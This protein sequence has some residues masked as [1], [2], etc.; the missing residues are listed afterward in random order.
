MMCK[1]YL[2]KA[3]KINHPW[4]SMCLRSAQ[5]CVSMRLLGV[6]MYRPLHVPVLL[7]PPGHVTRPVV[8][9]V[10]AQNSSSNPMC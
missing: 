5:G 3:A 6:A 2:S 1:L 9:K 8:L 7:F 4:A 10:W